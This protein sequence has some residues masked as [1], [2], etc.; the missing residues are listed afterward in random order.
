MRLPGIGGV[1]VRGLSESEGLGL[2]YLEGSLGQEALK[3]LVTGR[4][5]PPPS[6]VATTNNDGFSRLSFTI[7]SFDF[8]FIIP[9][10]KN[11]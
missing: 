10:C 6:P 5:Y 3:F 1:G 11:Y 2:V 8:S 9:K 4:N 7:I